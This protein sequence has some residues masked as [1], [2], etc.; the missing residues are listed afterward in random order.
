MRHTWTDDQKARA[1]GLGLAV[2]AIAASEQ[3][4]IPRRTITRWLKEPSGITTILRAETRQQ[5][6]ERLWTA[7]VEGTDAVLAGLKDPKARLGDKASALRIVVEAHQLISGGPTSRTETTTASS[8]RPMSDYERAQLRDWIDAIQG[9][10]D[11]ELREW[12]TEGLPKMRDGLI[13]AG[14]TDV[15]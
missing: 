1:V 8:V 2:G 4:G 10:T 5:V 6:A 11:D 13:E 15:G 3:T 12:A 9:S 7:V 14:G